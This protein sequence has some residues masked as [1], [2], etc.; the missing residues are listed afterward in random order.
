MIPF[1]F[2]IFRCSA[3]SL[4]VPHKHHQTSSSQAVDSHIW[5]QSKNIPISQL[6]I[7]GMELIPSQIFFNLPT[8]EVTS[9]SNI[10]RTLFRPMA[11]EEEVWRTPRAPSEAWETPFTSPAGTLD[12]YQGPLS[13]NENVNSAVVDDEHHRSRLPSLWELLPEYKPDEAIQRP[14]GL[15]IV[16]TPWSRRGVGT[17]PSPSAGYLTHDRLWEI[18]VSPPVYPIDGIDG[19]TTNNSTAT[20]RSSSTYTDVASLTNIRAR[21]GDSDSDMTADDFVPSYPAAGIERSHILPSVNPD[22]LHTTWRARPPLDVLDSAIEAWEDP[23]ELI[24]IDLDELDNLI[25]WV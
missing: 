6:A 14:R 9:A 16:M 19:T 13:Y 20:G 24:S 25:D 5:D 12:P 23:D 1:P 18:A 22:F 15:E 11:Y 3:V 10:T 4:L 17:V 7:L 21:G 8:I 2:I